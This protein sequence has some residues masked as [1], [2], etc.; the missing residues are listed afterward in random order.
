MIEV[1]H[2]VGP[3]CDEYYQFVVMVENGV[4]AGAEDGD[5]VISPEDALLSYP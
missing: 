1:Y 2:T 5:H 4:I 3:V